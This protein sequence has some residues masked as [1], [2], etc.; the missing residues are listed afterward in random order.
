M[1]KSLLT[2]VLC[3]FAFGLGF[4]LNNVAFSDAAGQK[5]AYVN[6][7]KLLAASKALKAAED[8]KVKQTQEM[9][10]WYNTASADIQKQQTEA[11]RKALINKYESQLTQKKKTI[12]DA[13]A[14]KVND[15]DNQLDTAITQKAKAM[16]YD[17]VFRKDAVL[18]GGT[19]IT[20]QILPLVK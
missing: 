12:K 20:A 3:S 6:V 4:G 11:G 17:L 5:V 10:K 15:V 2:L 19:D 8:A 13:Y 18:V 9:L 14:K 7:G 16:G 1:K